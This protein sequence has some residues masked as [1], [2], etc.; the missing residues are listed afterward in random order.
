MPLALA[1]TPI[2]LLV[3]LLGTNVYFFADDSSYGSNQMALLVAAFV[4]GGIGMLRGVSWKVIRDAISKRAGADV[5][6]AAVSRVSLLRFRAHVDDAR[7]LLAH[8]FHHPRDIVRMRVDDTN[9]VKLPAAAL[10]P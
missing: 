2:V 4:A 1:L 5:G 3:A 6:F 10:G 9:E 8:S 7:A